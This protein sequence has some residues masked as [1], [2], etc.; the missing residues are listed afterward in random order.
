[1]NSLAGF[2]IIQVT[3][4]IH[5]FMEKTHSVYAIRQSQVDNEMASV[6]VNPHRGLEFSALTAGQ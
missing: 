2:R 3:I 5:T 1:M 4:N 6:M